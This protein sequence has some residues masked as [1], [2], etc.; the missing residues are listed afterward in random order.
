MAQKKSLGGVL[1]LRYDPAQRHY[2]VTLYRE[3]PFQR[4]TESVS[5]T[6]DGWLDFRITTGNQAQQACILRSNNEDER[7]ACGI[8]YTAR[9]FVRS[10]KMGIPIPEKRASHVLP[11]SCHQ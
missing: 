4:Q 9:R 7:E 2:R 6:P 11:Y 5:F 10:G 3:T 8:L 1:T